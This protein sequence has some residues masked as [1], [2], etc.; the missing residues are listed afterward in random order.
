[1]RDG[2]AGDEGNRRRRVE[3]EA[4]GATISPR[5]ATS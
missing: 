2:R 3:F 1:V 4:H 5:R